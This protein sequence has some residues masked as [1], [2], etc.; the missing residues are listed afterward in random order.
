MNGLCALGSS[1]E[2]QRGGLASELVADLVLIFLVVAPWLYFICFIYDVF[3]LI[4]TNLSGS[5]LMV[6][7]THASN[8][9]LAP[10]SPPHDTTE[11]M[12][13]VTLCFHLRIPSSGRETRPIHGQKEGCPDGGTRYSSG[14]DDGGTV[15]LVL[16]RI[17]YKHG[18]CV[19]AIGAIHQCR[20]PVPITSGIHQCRS[21]GPSTQCRPS[22]PITSG[23]HQ[24]RS[25]GPST[26]A[27]HQCR[28][29]V[30]STSAGHQ[31]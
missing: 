6:Y 26:S 29:P 14:S 4:T 7:A 30:A 12:V 21:P 3:F 20:S 10:G 17:K 24:C 8:H 13:S 22:V 15:F 31:C 19:C 23:I 9:I 5:F 1:V 2:I 28:S 25:P 16:D 18:E 27:G 11:Y